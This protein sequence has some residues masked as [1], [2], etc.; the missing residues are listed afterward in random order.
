[1][2]K[3]SENEPLKSRDQEQDLAPSVGQAVFQKQ[4][5]LFPNRTHKQKNM[6]QEIL[7]FSPGPVHC[8]LLGGVGSG[9]YVV[10]TLVLV[11]FQNLSDNNGGFTWCR[12]IK[13]PVFQLAAPEV[14][15]TQGYA[16]VAFALC[17]V[18]SSPALKD[19]KRV[20]SLKTGEVWLLVFFKHQPSTFLLPL[21]PFGS[22]VL[23]SP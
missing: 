9:S 23:V 15:L 8:A 3:P 10:E 19:D 16:W 18:A 21:L 4:R 13:G 2:Q 17:P 12:S 5:I 6:P 7:H 22:M 1:M 14:G 11:S 20:I